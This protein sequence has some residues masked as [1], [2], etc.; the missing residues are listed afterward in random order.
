MPEEYYTEAKAGICSG[1]PRGIRTG[2]MQNVSRFPRL[3]LSFT[4]WQH[5]GN[6]GEEGQY[7]GTPA[8]GN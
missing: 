4:E 7:I 6:E 8:L 5:R 1:A 2:A 3:A